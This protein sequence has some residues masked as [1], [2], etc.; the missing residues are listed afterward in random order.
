MLGNFPEKSITSFAIEI[1][2]IL[3]IYLCGIEKEKCILVLEAACAGASLWL[4]VMWSLTYRCPLCINIYIPGT[5]LS[6]FRWLPCII[7]ER[8]KNLA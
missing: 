5:R 2:I 4:V 6:S 7:G 3:K 1:T 8:K